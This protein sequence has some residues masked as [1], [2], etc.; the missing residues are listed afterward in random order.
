MPVMPFIP[1]VPEMGLEAQI[2]AVSQ[3]TDDTL[4]WIITIFMAGYHTTPR[5]T[6]QKVM[7]AMANMAG[8]PDKLVPLE[9]QKR[10]SDMTY[11]V[12]VEIAA[13]EVAKARSLGPKPGNEP[14]HS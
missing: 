14:T 11:D 5:E 12:L 1:S 4:R 7:H 8:L 3:V 2:V 10:I 13:L 9:V 6:A